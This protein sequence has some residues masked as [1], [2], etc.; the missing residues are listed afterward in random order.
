MYEYAMQMNWTSYA[1][2]TMRSNNFTAIYREFVVIVELWKAL[3]KQLLITMPHE[4]Y[5]RYSN[6]DI[7]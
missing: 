5:Y 2:T 4:Q 6:L 3:L 1:A 7:L